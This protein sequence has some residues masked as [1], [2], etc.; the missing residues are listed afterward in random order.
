MLLMP[1]L[2]GS[3][4]CREP[5]WEA[6][7]FLQLQFAGLCLFPQPAGLLHQACISSAASYNCEK[8]EL[9]IGHA[10]P[11]SPRL[12]Q[13]SSRA[14]HYAATGS[15]AQRHCTSGEII[16]SSFVCLGRSYS[17]GLYRTFCMELYKFAA[18]PKVYDNFLAWAL[19]QCC[20]VWASSA[21]WS[22]DQIVGKVL[23][24]QCKLNSQYTSTSLLP[25]TGLCSHPG[26]Q[27]MILFTLSNCAILNRRECQDVAGKFGIWGAS[28][29]YSRLLESKRL[30][31]IIYAYS[32]HSISSCGWGICYIGKFREQQP[33]QFQ[34]SG[35]VVQLLAL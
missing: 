31:A 21:K 32:P 33:G 13:S 29:Q 27:C 6:W 26:Q 19:V 2:F 24:N 8:W 4:A 16:F 5:E 14:H 18:C 3:C 28:L 15:R 17:T 9:R 25:K 7:T 35:P 1:S 10:L 22:T 11:Q 20:T 12:E 34:H 23:D 30:N